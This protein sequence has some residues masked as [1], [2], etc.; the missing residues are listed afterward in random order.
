MPAGAL[1]IADENHAVLNPQTGEECPRACF[2]VRG[3][4]T[5]ADEAIGELVNRAGGAIF[6]G[7]Y[8]NEEAEAY[9]VREGAYWTGDLFYRDEEGYFYFAGRDLDWL[10]VDGENF[11]A[12]PVE[13]V[14]E[15]LPEVTLSA[16]YGVPDVETGD[17][18][19][20]AL[21]FREGESFDPELFARFLADQ[22]DLGTK[23]APR[24]VRVCRDVPKTETNKILKRQMRKEA[25]E[26]D[27][28]LW[29]RDGTG[30]YVPMTPEDKAALRRDLDGRGRS[31]LLDL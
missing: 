21:V 28:P 25:W 7:Y 20:A 9:S 14:L 29:R 19:M 15:R 16:V 23:W 13:R 1:G 8:K 12:A 5:N 10:R 18:V 6:E 30:A 26:C 24:Y 27:D 22:P 31:Y 17:Q 11:A 3:R 4:L 2:D